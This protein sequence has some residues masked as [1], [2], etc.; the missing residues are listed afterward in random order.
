MD[1]LTETVYILIIGENRIWLAMV[2]LA[3]FGVLHL[4]FYFYLFLER[5]DM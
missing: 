3:C 4:S 1:I 2:F 5:C